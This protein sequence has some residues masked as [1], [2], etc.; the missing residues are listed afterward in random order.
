MNALLKEVEYSKHTPKGSNAAADED[1]PPQSKSPPAD[2]PVAVPKG[3]NP[4]E[5]EVDGAAAGALPKGSKVAAEAAGAFAAGL[6][7]AVAAGI[8]FKP[9]GSS[10][11]RVAA[12]VAGGRAVDIVDILNVDE[13]G[14]VGGGNMPYPPPMVLPVGGGAP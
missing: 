10:S 11:T 2:D 9:K 1:V 7:E 5:D 6:V 12:V 3:S 14:A 4:E 13:P 8:E